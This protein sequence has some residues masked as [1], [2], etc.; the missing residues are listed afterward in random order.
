MTDPVTSIMIAL[1]PIAADSNAC[2]DATLPIK[3][4]HQESRPLQPG[5]ST[6]SRQ[7]PRERWPRAQTN[8]HP[9]AVAN[10]APNATATEHWPLSP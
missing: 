10:P 9:L 4:S 3:L 2:T 7:T 1:G 6:Q 5:R 8:R